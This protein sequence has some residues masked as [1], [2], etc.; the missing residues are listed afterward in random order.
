MERQLMQ[1]GGVDS[2][3]YLRFAAGPGNVAADG[4]FSIQ[5][6]ALAARVPRAPE[7]LRAAGRLGLAGLAGCA[8]LLRPSSLGGGDLRG[9]VAAGAAAPHHQPHQQP[10]PGPRRC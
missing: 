6:R 1:E 3:E 2:E 4:M 8:G 9:E 5:V 10:L 7:G